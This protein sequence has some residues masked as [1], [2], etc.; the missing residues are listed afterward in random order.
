MSTK[1]LA[2][3]ASSEPAVMTIDPEELQRGLIERGKSMTIIRSWFG[4]LLQPGRDYMIIPGTSKKD[5][6]G[7]ETA[8]PALLKPGAET[9]LAGAGAHLEIAELREDE[10]GTNGHLE[11]RLTIN[12]LNKRNE[13]LGQG[14]GSAS[15]LESRYSN[16]WVFGSDVPVDY[17]KSTLRTK[18]ISTKKG[19]AT[20]Y[21][22][23][24][25][26]HDSRNTVRKMAKKR[27]MVDAVLTAFGLS[28]LL[29]QD[30]DE[31]VDAETNSS[32]RHE[33]EPEPAPPPPR[34]TLSADARQRVSN[35]AAELARAMAYTVTDEKDREAMLAA[36]KDV[37]AK[38]IKDRVDTY[39]KRK[40]ESDADLAELEQKI[41]EEIAWHRENGPGKDFPL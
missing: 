33:A 11:V 20:M 31:D 40:V 2:P 13:P 36:G 19:K 7:N 35:A 15:T 5:K 34:P 29:A 8:R 1:E 22:I 28:G 23:E 12:I 16:R 4:K 25:N 38:I 10:I 27:A 39:L 17:D 3:V 30:L 18:E 32:P 37:V 9:I 26:A 41:R 21:C 14:I 6:D 24:G